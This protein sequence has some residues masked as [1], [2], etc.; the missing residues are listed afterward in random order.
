MKYGLKVVSSSFF[1]VKKSGSSYEGNISVTGVLLSKT[2]MARNKDSKNRE[3]DLTK[4]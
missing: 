3:Q 4:I 2:E 1:S